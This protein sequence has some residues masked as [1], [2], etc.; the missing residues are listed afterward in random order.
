M[1]SSLADASTA[2]ADSALTRRMAKRRSRT[3]LAVASRSSTALGFRRFAI[4]GD[5]PPMAMNYAMKQWA[6]GWAEEAA[7]NAEREVEAVEPLGDTHHC[8][9]YPAADIGTGYFEC[10]G[11]ADGFLI[12]FNDITHAAPY[13]MTI[14]APDLLRV[15]VASDD[16]AEYVSPRGDRLDL[17]GA[18]CAIIIEPAGMPPAQAVFAGHCRTASVY[19]HRSALQRLYAQR[20]HE[21]PAVLQAFIAGNLRQT[22]ARRLPLGAGL[23]RCLDDLHAC[24]LT[25]HSRRLFIRSKAIEILC[26]AF[27]AMAQEEDF[28]SPEASA[29]MTRGVLRAQRLLIDNFASPPSLDDLAREAGLSRSSLCAGFRQIV[30]Q[31]VFDYIADLRMQHALALLNQRDASITEI[32]YAVGYSHPSSFSLAVQRR[33]GTS[34]SELRRRGLPAI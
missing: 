7:R 14:S 33:F 4:A 27:K 22:V 9:A 8:R 13:P 32:A 11:L 15:R 5:L 12:H 10:C 28:G 17:K 25:E 16:D 21:L 26:H 1:R 20:E 23:I 30:G 3:E 6:A 34:P 2:P 31:T 24:D 19:I 29:L 18:G